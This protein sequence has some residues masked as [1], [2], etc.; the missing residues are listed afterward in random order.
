MSPISTKRHGDVLVVTSNNPPVNALGHAVRVGLVEAIEAADADDSVKAVVIVCQGQ[1]F[2]AGADITEFGKP[3]QMPMLPMVV[4]IIENCTKPV[5]AA[6]HGTAFGGGLE[7]ALASHY[8]VAVPSAKLGVP[9]VKLGLLPAPTAKAAA[10]RGVQGAGNGGDRQSHRRQE[11]HRPGRRLIEGDLEQQ[12]SPSPRRSRGRFPIL[13]A[14]RQ[15]GRGARAR[16]LRRIPRPMPASS[17][18]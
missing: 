18:A 7:V 15:G 14:R 11:A 16:H 6:I 12:R 4:D 5:V 3:M 17:R 9:E 2:F 10:R 8:R 1:T 13:R